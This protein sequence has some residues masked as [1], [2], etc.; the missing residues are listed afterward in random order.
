MAD[1]ALYHPQVFG[2]KQASIV[3]NLLVGVGYVSGTGW[4]VG[5]GLLLGAVG[6]VLA[7]SGF[8]WTHAHCLSMP[9]DD[10]ARVPADPRP[11]S[12]TA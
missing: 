5:V 10:T 2:G 1:V 4:L 7:L 9:T 12:V 8:G 6:T 11:T 3:A